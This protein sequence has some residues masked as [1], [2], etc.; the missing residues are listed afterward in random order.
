MT[1]RQAKARARDLWGEESV[2]GMMPGIRPG[3][4][5]VR[6]TDGEKH[7]LGADQRAYCH[8]ACREFSW[9]LNPKPLAVPVPGYPGA[10]V[11]VTK[12][13]ARGSTPRKTTVRIYMPTSDMAEGVLGKVFGVRRRGKRK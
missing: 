1:K 4:W 9:N 10:T 5:L 11:K 2:Y 13:R 12:T 3:S 6:T 8:P 7:S